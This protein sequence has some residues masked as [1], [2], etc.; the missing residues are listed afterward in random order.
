MWPVT[1]LVDVTGGGAS[2]NTLRMASASVASLSGVD[3]PCALTCP[4]RGGVETGVVEREL[5]ACS[6]TGA[7]GDGRGDVVGVGV[8]AVAEHLAV[9]RG[10]ARQR[11]LQRLE[12]GEARALGDHEPVAG[13]VERTR[14]AATGRRCGCSSRPCGRTPKP[15][16]A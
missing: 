5:H 8:A 10:A 15:S 12:H 3:V 14:R 7:A 6:R 13:G 2:P 9:D 16:A 1:P 11:V 4:M